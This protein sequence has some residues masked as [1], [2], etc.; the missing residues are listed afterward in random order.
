MPKRVVPLALLLATG[1]GCAADAPLGTLGL[2]S[3]ATKPTSVREIGVASGSSCKLGGI[4]YAEAVEDALRRRPGSNVL[5][6]ARF[7]LDS[8][9]LIW[10]CTHAAGMA[11]VV[12]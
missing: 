10:R 5:L 12:D 4:D 8:R 2:V 1:L 9:L 11:A 3:L 6:D 7:T